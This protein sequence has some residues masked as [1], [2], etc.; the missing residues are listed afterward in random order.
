ML[1]IS[2]IKIECMI[3]TVIRSLLSILQIFLQKLQ[4]RILLK[5]TILC[6]I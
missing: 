2:V 5:A 1:A 6:F 4:Q 3:E